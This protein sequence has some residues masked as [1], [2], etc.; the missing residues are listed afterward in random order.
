[1]CHATCTGT[2]VSDDIF[3]VAPL[4]E[5]LAVADELKQDPLIL[6]YP[7]SIPSFWAIEST[8]QANFELAYLSGMDA[9]ISSTGF[10][11]AGIP[12]GRGEWMQQ[13]VRGRAAAGQVDAGKLDIISDGLI[14]YQMLCFCQNTCLAVPWCNTSIPLISDTL[15]Q[16]HQVLLKDFG[17]HEWFV[18]GPAH[19]PVV[20]QIEAYNQILLLTLHNLP[21]PMYSHF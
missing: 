9:G 13:F 18:D 14:H 19:A 7:K 15:K 2:S 3:I 12:I 16:A 6:T 8:L 21:L 4:T 11:V 5:G 20:P 17:Y 10:S 1:V